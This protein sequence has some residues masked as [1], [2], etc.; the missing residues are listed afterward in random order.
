[1]L[2]S[3]TASFAPTVSGTITNTG[4]GASIPFRLHD[5]AEMRPYQLRAAHKIFTGSPN[6]FGGKDGTALILDMGLGKTIIVLQAVTELINWGVLTKPILIVAPI[7]VCNTVWRQEAAAWNTTRWLRFSLLRGKESERQYRLRKPAHIYLINPEL[8]QWLYQEL[9]RSWD[10]FDMLVIDESSMFKSPQAKRFKV[11]SNYGDRHTLKDINGRSIR[12]DLGHPM[13]IGAHRFKRVVIM[14]GT[15]APTSL[16]NLW[17][18]MYLVDHGYRLHISYNDFRERFF[19]K[20]HE[21]AEHVFEYTVHENELEVR[22]DWMP[23]DG[24]PQ[25]I[26]ELIADATVE[27]SAED[28]SIMPK[29]IGDASKGPI[30]PTHL[31]YVEL[32]AGVRTLYDQMEKE[33]LIE[34]NNDFIMACHGGAK[35][36]LCHQIA[37]GFIYHN[38]DHGRQQTDALHAT[39]LEKMLEL[40]ELIDSNVVITFHF[41]ADRDR[42]V[43]ALRQAGIGFGILTAANSERVLNLWNS[44]V[45]PVMLLHP[46]SAGHGINA[47]Q[48]GH[49]IIWYSQIWSLERYMQTNA[50]LA[51][52]GQTSI[53]GIHHIAARKTVDELM[54]LTYLE[55]GDTQSKFRSALRKY[56]SLR[57]WSIA[58][59]GT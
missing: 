18:P 6:A 5:E 40:I 30:P 57:G 17:A 45:L 41:K 9:G 15:P 55:R 58:D 54:L 19:Y 13:K 35:S 46:Q 23:K 36:M 4:T 37:N 16:L 32:P 3:S 39:K 49:H 29:T 8:L 28:Y 43:T 47:Q 52:S 33:A 44:G 59:E 12:D 14:T 31:H 10:R 2:E 26:H 42:I 24:A 56:Q 34:L 11:L 50:R 21:V 20:R 53:V 22:P 38:D 7:A 51:R 1:M 25:K 48:G 27:L